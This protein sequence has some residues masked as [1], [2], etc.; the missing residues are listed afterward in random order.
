MPART[1]CPTLGAPARRQAAA[2]GSSRM[3]A[4]AL[5]LSV[6]T[7]F[8]RIIESLTAL[9][10]NVRSVA[11]L[12]VMIVVPGGLLLAPIVY[13]WFKS[14]HA[15]LAATLPRTRP[16]TRRPPVKEILPSTTVPE[17]TRL[18]IRFCGLVGFAPNIEVPR[19]Q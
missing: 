18:S 11:L 8:S 16:S 1:H 5:L 6:F 12:L 3:S 10:W 15:K 9:Q 4:S 14:D 7:M 13:R 2:I 17:P 19:L